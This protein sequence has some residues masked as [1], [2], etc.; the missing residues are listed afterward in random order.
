[1]SGKISAAGVAAL[2]LF[3][4]SGLHGQSYSP[5]YNPVTGNPQYWQ[6]YDESTGQPIPGAYW[7][8]DAQGYWAGSNDHLHYSPTPPISTVSPLYGYADGAGNFSFELVTT[9][10][11]QAEFYDLTCSAPGYEG[12]SAE[13]EYGVGYNDIFYVGHPEIFYQTGGNTTNH[14]DNSGNH[15]MMNYNDCPGSTV[16]VCSAYLIYYTSIAYVDLYNAGELVCDNDMALPY[17]GK[18]DINNSSGTPLAPWASPHLAHDRG[19][20]VDIAVTSTQCPSQYVVTDPADFLS[21]AVNRY[22]AVAY[23]VSYYGSKDIHCNFVNP[24]TYPH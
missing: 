21:L 20:A 16:H 13:W 11:G 23:P 12:D 3:V 22:N 24:N 15:W 5:L 9:L 10:I 7:Q 2:V 4:T 19:S 6:C 17:G 1:M 8:V 18:F 14:G